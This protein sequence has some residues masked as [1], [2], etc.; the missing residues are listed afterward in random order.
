[1]TDLGAGD[2]ALEVVFTPAPGQKLDESFGPALRLEVS[3]SPP[4]LLA[5]GG[6]ESA[7]LRR[8][9]RLRAGEGVLQVTAQAATCDAGAEHPACHLTRQD[10]GVPVRVADGGPQRLVLVLRGMDPG[11]RG[12]GLGGGD[13]GGADRDG[14]AD[15]SN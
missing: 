14:D 10:W 9:L 12:A 8:A 11:F 6:G 13:G 3:A 4:E 15:P 2:V 5:D 7:D 1:V